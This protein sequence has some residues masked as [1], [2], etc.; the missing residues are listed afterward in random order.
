MQAEK[1]GLGSVDT[2]DQPVVLLQSLHRR[3]GQA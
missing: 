1:A 3:P 2:S